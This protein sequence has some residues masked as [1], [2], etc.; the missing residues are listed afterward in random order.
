MFLKG[1]TSRLPRE[2]LTMGMI[3]GMVRVQETL[4]AGVPRQPV[5]SFHCG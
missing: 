3:T 5:A 1:R 2:G 4:A